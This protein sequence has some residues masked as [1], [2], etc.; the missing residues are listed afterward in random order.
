MPP[1]ADQW[2]VRKIAAALGTSASLVDQAQQMGLIRPPD[3]AGRWWSSAAV[4]EIRD[5]WPTVMADIEAASELGAVRCAELLARRTGLPVDP[6]DVEELARRGML[7][8]TRLYKQR[9]LYR[10]T[11]VEA[12]AADPVSRAVLADIA[13]ESRQVP[14]LPGQS[15]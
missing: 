7:K 3:L 13:A 10:V 5:R 8:V 2:D 14:W 1:P 6:A 12:V 15:G 4:N 9:P 11:Q